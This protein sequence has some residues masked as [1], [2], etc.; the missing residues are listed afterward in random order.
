MSKN[1]NISSL[2]NTDKLVCLSPDA[3]VAQAAKK[4]SEKKVSAVMVTYGSKL[5]G[6]VTEQDI[7]F[8]TVARGLSV[9]KTTLFEIMTTTPDTLT[10]DAPA[11]DALNMM[12]ENGYR[13]VPVV[14][15]EDVIGV[16]SVKD[17]FK[18]VRKEMEEDLLSLD[19]FIS[20]SSYSVDGASV[21]H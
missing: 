6:I 9:D 19:Q 20:G 2:I 13:H 12:Q 1:G 7:T 8:R 21:A 10:A 4:M 5:L 14:S 17:I 16:I 15:G 18:E 3:S 11:V